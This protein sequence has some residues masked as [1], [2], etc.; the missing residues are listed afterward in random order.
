[1]TAIR[2]RRKST[3]D[4]FLLQHTLRFQPLT[5]TIAAPG[6]RRQLRNNALR[7]HLADAVE[8]L[9]AVG[10]NVAAVANAVL[11]VLLD[12]PF[13][14]R[15]PPLQRQTP[16]VVSIEVQQVECEVRKRM[17]RTLVERGLQFGKTR[18]PLL[19][20]HDDLAI[21]D[22]GMHRKLGCRLGQFAHA[23]RPVEAAPSE[24]AC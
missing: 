2:K 19:V 9:A 18:Q 14:N 10:A 1:M 13:E 8:H 20:E 7:T 16:Q 24:E 17:R 6:G 22:R 12:Q 11:T 21:D 4:K 3:Y 23:M 15:L 5:R